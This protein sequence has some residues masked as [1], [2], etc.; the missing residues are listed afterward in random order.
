MQ[1]IKFHSSFENPNMGQPPMPQKP[2]GS[3]SRNRIL[4]LT[5]KIIAM[6]AVAAILIMLP[7]WL[8]LNL[9]AIFSSSS[10]TETINK[11]SFSAVFLSNGQVYFGQLERSD[12]TEMVLKNVFYLQVADNTASASK[13]SILNQTHFNLIKLGSELHGPTD[14]LFVNRSQVLFYEYLRDDSKLVESI[15]N[16]KQ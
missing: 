6:I 15:K 13:S 12:Q 14:E 16:Y 3:N 1:E 11:E 4:I 5:G 9:S 10:S 2:R 7:R 8:H